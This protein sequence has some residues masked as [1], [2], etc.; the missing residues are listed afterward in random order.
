V[1]ATPSFD[2]EITVEVTDI[3]HRVPFWFADLKETL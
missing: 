2:K 3:V 1:T